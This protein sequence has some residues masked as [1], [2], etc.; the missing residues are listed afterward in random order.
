MLL[1]VGRL[2]GGHRGCL[3]STKAGLV[4]KMK[5]VT[6]RFR[7]FAKHPGNRLFLLFSELHF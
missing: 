6:G 3:K 4:D 1:N 2:G 7:S 5:V